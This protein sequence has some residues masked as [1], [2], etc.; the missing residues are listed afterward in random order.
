MVRVSSADGS[1]PMNEFERAAAER[2]P[3]LVREFWQFLRHHKRWW[4]VPILLAL[5]LLGLLVAA[6][7]S[8]AAPF[9]YPLF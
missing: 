9:V 1:E 6:S 7:G 2:P 8:V 3:G 5:A 4:L